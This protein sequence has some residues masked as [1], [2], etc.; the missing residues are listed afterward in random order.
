MN[1][2]S[3]KSSLAVW[4][5]VTGS[6]GLLLQYWKHRGEH[7]RFE[8]AAQM[9]IY[10]EPGKQELRIRATATNHG[11]RRGYVRQFKA[12]F[13]VEPPFHLGFIP[14]LAKPVPVEPGEEK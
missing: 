6:L 1:W 8:I 2:E 7:P 5:A 12:E 3:I 4:G 10:V 9:S 13:P 14:E 11:Q